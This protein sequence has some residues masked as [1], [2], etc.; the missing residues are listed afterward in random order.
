[1]L[2]AGLSLGALAAAQRFLLPR[3]QQ[4]F[5]FASGAVAPRIL[6]SH[7]LLLLGAGALVGLLG[8]WLAVARFL[9]T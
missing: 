7:A 2:G 5:V 6:L 9:R 3:V 8:S 1:M 4:A